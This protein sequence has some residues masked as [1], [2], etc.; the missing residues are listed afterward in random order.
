MGKIEKLLKNSETVKLPAEKP[1]ALP[2]NKKF[3][4][5]QT[6]VAWAAAVML[7]LSAFNSMKYQTTGVAGNMP[8]YYFAL[9]GV[10]IVY[11]LLALRCALSG[12]VTFDDQQ[13][14][15]PAFYPFMKEKLA[16]DDVNRAELTGVITYRNY[17]SLILQKI[18]SSIFMN[19]E[20]HV[21]Y[22]NV[23]GGAK[24][25]FPV[26]DRVGNKAA[27]LRIIREKLGE[28]FTVYEGE[29]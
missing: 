3:Y 16:W 9:M 5:L 1:Y 14:T 4:L 27:A 2:V 21:T 10:M 12:K 29:Y 24:G 18:F 23:P 25:N 22:R 17:L 20:L 11:G 6:V 28:R 19:V 13:I 8:I 7:L 26:L 15:M